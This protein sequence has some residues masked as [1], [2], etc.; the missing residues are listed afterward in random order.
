MNL[1]RGREAVM[2]TF[3]PALKAHGL[4]PQ[5]WRVLRVLVEYGQLDISQL[6]D[7]TFLLPPSLSRIVQNLEQR[8]IVRRRSVASDQRRS[9]ISVSARGQRLF[10]QIA[11]LS[12]AR[13]RHIAERFGPGK[14]ELLYELLD[15]L[16]EKLQ[17]E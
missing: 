11:P 10:D 1:L 15:E 12:E 6:A 7:R 4:T 2:R 5:Q 16:V 14:L 8:G 17:D 13:Y 3:T 9:A